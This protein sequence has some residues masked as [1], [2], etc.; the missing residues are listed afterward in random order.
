MVR[1]FCILIFNYFPIYFVALGKETYDFID[2]WK[3]NPKIKKSSLFVYYSIYVMP[4]LLLRRLLLEL[5]H[6]RNLPLVLLLSQSRT[7]T[8]A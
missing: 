7:L 2:A 6:H 1:F 8:T 5:Q 4:Q 3:H